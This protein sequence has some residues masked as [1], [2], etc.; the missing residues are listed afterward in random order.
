MKPFLLPSLLALTLAAAL[1]LSAQAHRSWLLPSKSLVNGGNQVITV[2]GSTS[3]NL[4]QTDAFALKLDGL[5]ITAPDGTLVTP[6]DVASAKQRSSFDLTLTQDGTYRI[7]VAS[8]TV[9]ASYM[10]NGELQRYRGAAAGMASQIP[11]AATDVRVAHTISRYETWVTANTPSEAAL[12][13]AGTGLEIIPLSDPSAYVAG[14]AAKFRA[15][16]DGKPL[17]GLI[18][19]VIPGGVRYR[20]D[21]Q[22]TDVTTD[23]K[24]EISITWPIGQMYWIGASYPP[25][26]QDGGDHDG[27]QPGGNRGG[28]QGGGEHPGGQGQG[29]GG[30]EGRG[31]GGGRGP[32]GPVTPGQRYSYAGTFEVSPF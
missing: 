3:E 26:P 24:G 5:T 29:A 11:A 30:G 27:G 20:G 31:P 22:E 16:L 9:M 21:M 15:Y 10:L 18:V 12:K 7:A 8:D 6:D 23:A 2:D 28:Q 4:F 13:P 14:E 19:Q 25:R 17:A 1:P 32:Q